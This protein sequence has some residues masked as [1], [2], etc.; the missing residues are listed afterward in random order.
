MLKNSVERAVQER[1]FSNLINQDKGFENSAISTYQNLVYLRY[2]EVIK[3]NFPLLLELI[4]EKLLEESIKDFMKNTPTTP[5]VWKIPNDYRKFVKKT[6]YFG[7]KSFFYE[8]LYFD[9]VE[10]EIYMNEYKLKKQ[11]KFSYKN[12]YKLSKSARIKRF[13]YDI[14]NQNYTTKKENFVVIYYDF[15]THDVI[16]RE[17]NQLIFELLKRVDKTQSLSKVLKQLCLENDIEFKE[18]KKLLKEP[19]EELYQNRVLQAL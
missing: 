10:V 19:L 13:E 6:K 4:E 5:Y 3:N 17:I 1:F 14:I 7:K 12:S 15:E 2:F 18:A 9:W 8:L 16:Y 11:K